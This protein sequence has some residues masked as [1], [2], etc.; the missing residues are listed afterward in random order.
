V[1][2]PGYHIFSGLDEDAV[3]VEGVD[4]LRNAHD[5]MKKLAAAFP[6]PYFLYCAQ[7]YAIVT[8]LDISHNINS[9]IQESQLIS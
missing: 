2:I 4:R 5:R 3:W 9:Q 8:T 7:T 6:G 1:T